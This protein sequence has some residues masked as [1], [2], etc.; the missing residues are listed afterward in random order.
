MIEPKRSS[1]MI[2]RRQFVYAGA[3]ALALGVRIPKA[4]AASYDLLIK[5]GRVID[6]SA[7]LDAVR[8]IAIAG[9]RKKRLTAFASCASGATWRPTRASYGGRWIF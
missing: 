5:G 2:H 6:P 1:T 3:A 7:G 4:F 8:D 9:G